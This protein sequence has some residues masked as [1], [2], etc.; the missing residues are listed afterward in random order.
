MNR[1]RTQTGIF[2]MFIAVFAQ[3]QT[4]PMAD[5]IRLVNPSFED[6]PKQSSPPLGWADCGFTGESAPDVHPSNFW[7]VSKP[8]QNGKTYVGLVVRNNDTWERISQMLE[9]PL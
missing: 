7:E 9:S 4:R 5:S 6:V 1:S 2:W 3:A 8:A